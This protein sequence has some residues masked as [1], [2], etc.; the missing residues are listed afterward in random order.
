M[1]FCANYTWAFSCNL[2]LKPPTQTSWS[3]QYCFPEREKEREREGG[4]GLGVGGGEKGVLHEN[5]R[6]RENERKPGNARILF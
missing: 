5:E 6:E 1:I 3:T 2:L 4:R